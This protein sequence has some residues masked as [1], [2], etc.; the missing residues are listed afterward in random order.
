MMPELGKYA[1]TVLSAWG[2]TLVLL[3]GLIGLTLW[4]SRRVRRALDAQERKVA[5]H[6]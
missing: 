2:V 1:V 5:R 6:G 3:A 4:Q